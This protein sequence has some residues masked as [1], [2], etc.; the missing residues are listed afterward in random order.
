MSNEVHALCQRRKVGSPTIKAVLMYMS[1]RAADDGSGIWCSKSHMAADLEMSKRTVQNAIAELIER[2]L[3][4]ECGQ[5]KCDRGF[6]V[7]Y[8]INLDAISALEATREKPVLRGAGDSPVQ[9]IHPKGCRR[10]TSTGAGDSPNTSLEPS[11]E[12][13]NVRESLFQGMEDQIEPPKDRFEDFWAAY[14]KCD[15]KTDKPKARELFYS[16]VMGRNKKISKTDAETIINGI[17]GYAATDPD[18]KYIPMPTTWLNGAR[19]DVTP[20]PPTNGPGGGSPMRGGD[21]AAGGV[22]R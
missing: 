14:P 2:G 1:D 5:R 12:P 6:T 19:W 16:I 18:P 22:Y 21:Y 4:N 8:R 13:S 7:D 10:F 20:V 15:R 3:I 17:K 9:E 11:L